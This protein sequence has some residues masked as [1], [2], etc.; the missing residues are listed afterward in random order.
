MYDNSTAGRKNLSLGAGG[1][2]IIKI[3]AKYVR[4]T[5]HQSD[6]VGDGRGPFPRKR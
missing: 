1:F 5:G 4:M 6:S 2:A 3:L